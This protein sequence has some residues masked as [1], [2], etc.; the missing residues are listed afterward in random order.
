MNYIQ[1]VLI[2]PR[3]NKGSLDKHKDLDTDIS[4]DVCLV[5]V[6]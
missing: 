2:F 4:T 6:T 3:G 5:K 1:E